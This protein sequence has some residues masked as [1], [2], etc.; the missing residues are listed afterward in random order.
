MRDEH[1]IIDLCD[2]ILG[3]KAEWQRRFDF[4]RGDGDPGRMLPVDAFY[5][6]LGLVIE[7]RERQHSEPVELWD[8]RPTISGV[9]R[10]LQ[11][12]KYDR[13]RRRI[14]P[15]HGMKLVELSYADFEHDARKRLY[16]DPKRDEK[17]LCKK[18]REW[19]TMGKQRPT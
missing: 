18:L 10:G 15:R 9:P 19:V 17:V 13:R 12:A 16:R 14:L 7:Y 6:T 5:P 8:R 11:R 2:E 3:M 1:Y 4:L